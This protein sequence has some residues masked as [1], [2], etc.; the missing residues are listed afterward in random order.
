MNIAVVF[1]ASSPGSGRTA[2]LATIHHEAAFFKISTKNKSRFF[3]SHSL[4]APFFHDKQLWQNIP[5]TA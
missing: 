4:P 5:P 3:N 1:I 2:I